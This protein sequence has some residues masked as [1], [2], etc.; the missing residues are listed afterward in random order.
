[1]LL[2]IKNQKA[3]VFPVVEENYS[4]LDDPPEPKILKEENTT[5]RT[6]RER[7]AWLW[8]ASCCLA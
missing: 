1:M 2:T 6:S 5:S 3:I 4:S 8:P 7:F